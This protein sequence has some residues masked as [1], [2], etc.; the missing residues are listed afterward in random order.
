[1]LSEN[2]KLISVTLSKKGGGII[3]TQS[4]FNLSKVLCRTLKATVA[5]YGMYCLTDYKDD[6]NVGPVVS[7][8]CVVSNLD[9]G[10]IYMSCL[11]PQIDTFSPCK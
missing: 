2:M 9:Y 10:H 3:L 8:Y 4:Q 11:L 7:T 1:M 5:N 6:C